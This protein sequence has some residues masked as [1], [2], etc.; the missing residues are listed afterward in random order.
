ME[1][2]LEEGARRACRALGTQGDAVAALRQEG[3]HLLLDDV[4][5]VADA[6]LKEVGVFKNG[7][8]QLAVAEGA[9][10]LAEELLQKL[11]AV[12]VAREDVLRAARFLGDQS[13]CIKPFI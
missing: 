11:P 8:S 4:G 2:V 13:H 9:R 3:V 5:G 1:T 12:A 10:F 6:A 7:G